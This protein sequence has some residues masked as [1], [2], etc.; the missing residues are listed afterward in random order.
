MN[1]KTFLATA[2]LVV[3]ASLGLVGCTGG[4]GGQVDDT[5][6]A[7]ASTTQAPTPQPVNLDGTW[8]QTNAKSDT[9]Y[10]QATISDG[11]ISIDWVA[12]SGDST[13]IYWVGSVT[14]PSDASTTFTW[15]STRDKAKTEN[16][17]LASR[18]DTKTFTYADGEIS[19]KVTA[20]GTTTTVRLGR[21]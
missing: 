2:A 10:Q 15:E 8:K 7:S 20:L 16:A 6:G 19:Y 11:V 12:D 4:G 18:D 14:L 17:L 1:T 21:Q 3:V 9:N 5:A 13:S